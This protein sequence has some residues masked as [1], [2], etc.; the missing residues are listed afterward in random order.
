MTKDIELTENQR[1][2]VEKGTTNICLNGYSIKKEG[3]QIIDINNIGGEYAE[4]NICDCKYLRRHGA[5]SE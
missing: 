2:F 1:I 4:L 5:G 3:D